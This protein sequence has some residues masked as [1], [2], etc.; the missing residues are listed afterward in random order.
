MEG[1]ADKARDSA[2]NSR[3]KSGAREGRGDLIVCTPTSM[4]A[5][6]PRH[7][8]GQGHAST[9]TLPS[10][11]VLPPRKARLGKEKSR[12]PSDGASEQRGSRAEVGVAGGK[13]GGSEDARTRRGEESQRAYHAHRFILCTRMSLAPSCDS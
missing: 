8:T 13:L 11:I 4:A 12:I 10:R 1:A 9:A 5:K 6:P 7:E 2:R 3:D